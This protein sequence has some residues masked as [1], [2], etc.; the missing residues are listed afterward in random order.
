MRKRKGEKKISF[1][2]ENLAAFQKINEPCESRLKVHASYIRYLLLFSLPFLYIL[3]FSWSIIMISEHFGIAG[4][5][6]SPP[7]FFHANFAHDPPSLVTFT[8]PATKYTNFYCVTSFRIT[9]SWSPSHVS[10]ALHP[11][12][13]QRSEFLSRYPLSTVKPLPRRDHAG[14]IV[15]ISIPCHV[16]RY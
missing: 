16:N 10:T 9:R 2:H 5:T 7:V 4:G 11:R 13:K 15:K 3:H 8:R 6:A 1:W 12:R 14:G